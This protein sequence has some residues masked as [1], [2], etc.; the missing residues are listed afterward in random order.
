VVLTV[1]VSAVFMLRRNAPLASLGIALFLGCHTLTATI[2][3]LELIYEHRNYFASAG[4]LIAL[5]SPLGSHRLVALSRITKLALAAACMLLASNWL[6]QTAR[7]TYAW[8]DQLRLAQELAI[9]GIDSPRAQYELG[10]MYIIYSNY[11]PHSR[12]TSAAYAPLERSAA[13]PKSS[14][15][16]EQALI[17]MNSR[18][19]LPLK[20]EWWNSINRKLAAAPLTVQDDSSLIAL[21]TCARDE[22][23]DIPEEPLIRAYQTALMHEKPSAR[24]LASYGDYVWNVL[25]DQKQGIALTQRAIQS[26]P[27]EPVYRVTLVRMLTESGDLRGATEALDTLT[28]MN[29]GGSLSGDIDELHRLIATAKSAH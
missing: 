17:F 23:C 4:L 26:S 7:T 10:R 27:N 8:G 13:L 18:M 1:L 22:R 3:P 21:E 5:A 24:L 20:E 15:L 9:R 12:F 11:D 19:K 28:K 6:V 16:A 14:I 29:I 2:L 25:D